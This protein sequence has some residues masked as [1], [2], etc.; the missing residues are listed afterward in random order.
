M[1]PPFSAAF[2]LSPAESGRKGAGFCKSKRSAIKR[3][4]K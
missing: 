3:E 1:I 2:S 4:G